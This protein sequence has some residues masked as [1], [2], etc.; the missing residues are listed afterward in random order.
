[1]KVKTDIVIDAGPEAVWSVFD[2]AEHMSRWQPTFT[3]TEKRKPSFVAGIYE[4]P[5][6][7]A[8]VVYH[9]EAIEEN[10]TRWS[11][12]ANHQFSGIRKLTAAFNRNAIL[13]H[14]EEDMQRLKLLVETESAASES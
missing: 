5:W 1:M 4:S 7:K 3:I 11:V 12:F 10:R 8:I 6:S 13:S 14:T 2:D 9:F